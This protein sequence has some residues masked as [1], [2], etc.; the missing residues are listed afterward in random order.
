MIE[1]P[2]GFRWGVSLSG[3]QFEMGDFYNRYIDT[4]TDWWHWVRDAH[5]V[6]SRLVSGD[7]PEDGVNYF[8]LYK[9]DHE[10]AVWLGLNIYRIGVEWS[11]VFPHPTWF[12][13]VDVE[14]DGNG[15]V[16]EVKITK[17]TLEK[18]DRIANEDAISI[19]R[20]IILDLRRRGI[21]VVVNLL[22]FTL[23][24]WLHNP[25]RARSTNLARGPNGL[26]EDAFPVEFAKYAAYLAYKLGDLV[27]AWSTM[28]EPMVPIELG[29]MAP[30]SGFPPGVNRPDVV[31]KAFA[32]TVI[33]HALAYKQ[34]K[35]F[36]S[37]KADP[38]SR[39]SAEV[40]IIHN[41]I[42][43]YP[44]D[45]SSGAASEHQVYF[46]NYML[47]EA[48]TRGKVDVGLDEKTFVT[49]PSAAGT[50]DW[51]G[52]NYYTRIVIKKKDRAPLPVLDFEAIPGYGYACVPFSTS[53][54][55]RW[56]DGMGWEMFPEGLTESLHMAYRYS[57]NLYIT[58]N[59]TS[60]PRDVSRAKYTVSHLYATYRAIEQGLR[61]HGYLHWSIIDNYEWAHGF[62][63]KF[64]LFEVDLITK[65]R[66]P[67]HSAK[68]FREI[69][70]SN[71]IKADYLNMVI[72]EER[73]PGDIL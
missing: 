6:S 12:V 15:F 54:A 16:K 57:K 32:N 67:R 18:L 61:V 24:Y 27:D 30:H 43:A 35:R 51:L 40:G 41:F 73:P 14:H 49:L 36:D 53:K 65:E 50:L 13:E 58:E 34:I 2:G 19:Y 55:G 59:G 17:E 28:N 39:D 9:V 52:V 33:A 69:A 64:G 66:K 21:K 3:F 72:Y 37:V 5:N 4:N 29:Y 20:E 47:L 71:S 25:V 38:D 44:I 7:L 42:P 70:T 68:I 45:E 31:P 10:N 22:H 62:R 48:V 11:R 63:Q 46:H 8:G 23:P 26:I 1:F 56:C 60:D